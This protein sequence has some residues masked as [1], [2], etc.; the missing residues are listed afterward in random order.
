LCII[1]FIHVCTHGQKVPLILNEA[2]FMD[3]SKEASGNMEIAN[4][5]T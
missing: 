5:S 3:N 2:T 1:S 4:A